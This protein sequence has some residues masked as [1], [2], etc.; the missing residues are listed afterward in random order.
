MINTIVGIIFTVIAFGFAYM[1]SHIIA[2]RK[3]GKH[4]PLPW[5]KKEEIKPDPKNN[6]D[7][8]KGKFDKQRVAYRPEDNT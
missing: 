7:L 2:E 6:P 8:G 5:E 3:A 4:I 1:T